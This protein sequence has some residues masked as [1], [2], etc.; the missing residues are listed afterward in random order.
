MR[1]FAKRS[2][3]EQWLKLSCLRVSYSQSLQSLICLQIWH[4]PSASRETHRVC[5]SFP[6]RCPRIN[7]RRDWVA[8]CQAS[9]G[10]QHLGSIGWP[11]WWRAT[12]LL[13]W[14]CHPGKPNKARTLLWYGLRPH[15]HLVDHR[16]S[17]HK[18]QVRSAWNKLRSL[19]SP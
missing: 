3:N 15:L 10:W 4:H 14:V 8:L 2:R 7:Y 6:P 1:L 9:Q 11:L 18:S 13:S 5:Q 12:S 16:W 17:F 19:S